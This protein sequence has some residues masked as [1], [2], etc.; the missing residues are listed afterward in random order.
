VTTT[1]VHCKRDRYDVYIGRGSDW[2][3]P[4]THLPL[5]ETLAIYQVDSRE[6]AIEKYRDWIQKQ[7]EMLNRLHEL[8]DKVLGCWCHPLPCHGDILAEL[9]NQ[10]DL[11]TGPAVGIRYCQCSRC[12]AVVQ[13]R[14]Q[15]RRDYLS[16]NL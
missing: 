10:P 13:E 14:E 12:R 16:G 3:N 9:A 7:P 2:G 5:D 11:C 4:F 6:E 15:L 8:K 1:V